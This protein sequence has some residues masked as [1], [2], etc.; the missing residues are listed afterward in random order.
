M[1]NP[2][3]VIAYCTM[4]LHLELCV[5]SYNLRVHRF[6]LKVN[7][8]LSIPEENDHHLIPTGID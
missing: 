3:V 8:S 5:S 2:I 7:I 6:I 4:F 1:F